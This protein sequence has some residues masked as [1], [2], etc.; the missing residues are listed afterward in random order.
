MEFFCKIKIIIIIC[1]RDTT[2]IATKLRTRVLRPAIV[3]P[4]GKYSVSV[5][6]QNSIDKMNYR[7]AEKMC[8]N[9]VIVKI[10]KI[11]S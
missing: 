3:L 6:H 9:N 5:T 2:H 10:V 8:S 7:A 1:T 11:H 4:M